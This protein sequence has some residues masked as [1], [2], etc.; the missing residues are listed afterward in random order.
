MTET[1]FTIETKVKTVREQF[2]QRHLSGAGSGALFR[3]ESLGWFV[4]LEGSYESNFAGH[5]KPN[6]EIGDPVRIVVEKIT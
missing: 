3:R 4:C 6:L 5:T 1:I 2:I